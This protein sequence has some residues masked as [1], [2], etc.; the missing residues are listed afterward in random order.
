MNLLGIAS[1]FRSKPAIAS[2]PNKSKVVDE[3][4]FH[5]LC[6]VSL[7]RLHFSGVLLGRDTRGAC[8]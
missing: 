1:L 2:E 3:I 6:A 7:T 8:I 5:A 4:S